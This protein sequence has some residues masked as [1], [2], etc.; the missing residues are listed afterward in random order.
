MNHAAQR[1]TAHLNPAHLLFLRRLIQ[2]SRNFFYHEPKIK[3][4][5][6]TFKYHYDKAKINAIKRQ[7][8]AGVCPGLADHLGLDKSLVRIGFVLIGFITALISMSPIVS[9]RLQSVRFCI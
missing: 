2:L 9:A 1:F 8:I 6:A 5:F 7:I 4:G 3:S